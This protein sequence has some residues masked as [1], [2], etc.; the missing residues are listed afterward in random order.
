MW[1]SALHLEPPHPTRDPAPWPRPGPGGFPALL[2]LGDPLPPRTGISC[3]TLVAPSRSAD[4]IF[5]DPGP[6]ACPPPR[7]LIPSAHR[8]SPS[9]SPSRRGFTCSEDLK[10]SRRHGPR[11]FRPWLCPPPLTPA[12]SVEGLLGRAEGRLGSCCAL[13]RDL[14]LSGG[15]WAF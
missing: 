5:P 8:A 14:S 12:A 3:L 15:C 11:V 4:L 9:Q 1:V 7:G 13:H 2:S 6:G 10:P